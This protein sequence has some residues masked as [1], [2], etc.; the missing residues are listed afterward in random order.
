MNRRSSKKHSNNQ[1][2]I[3]V[4]RSTDI[5]LLHQSS[6]KRLR[7]RLPMLAPVLPINTASATPRRLPSSAN[8]SPA[9]TASPQVVGAIVD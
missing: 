1:S 2:L 8:M 3:Y 5:H 7:K 6:V 9:G 4:D